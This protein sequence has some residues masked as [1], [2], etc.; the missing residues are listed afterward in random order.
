MAPSVGSDI[1]TLRIQ[2]RIPLP[3]LPVLQDSYTLNIG[4]SRIVGPG[5][6]TSADDPFVEYTGRTY[7]HLLVPGLVRVKQGRARAGAITRTLLNLSALLHAG[8]AHPHHLMPACHDL[9]NLALLGAIAGNMQ[10]TSGSL[11]LTTEVLS[12]RRHHNAGHCL[13][14]TTQPSE[15]HQLILR[16]W[17]QGIPINGALHAFPLHTQLQSYLKLL[18]GVRSAAARHLACQGSQDKPRA[19]QAPSLCCFACSADTC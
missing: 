13:Q 6:N 9:G 15:H 19:A 4:I 2:S 11:V 16:L 18:Q 14:H 5:D 3:S 8:S 1:P 7:N 17:F 10:R 12:L